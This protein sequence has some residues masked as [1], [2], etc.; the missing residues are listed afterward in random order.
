MIVR[1]RGTTAASPACLLGYTRAL[2]VLFDL[3]GTLT[4][5]EPGITRCL[6]HALASL[7]HPV[8]AVPD[9]RRFVGPPLGDT[10]ATLLG[11]SDEAQIR[12][13]VRCYRER[14]ET[15]GLYENA[16]YPDV[17]AGLERLRA[18][19]HRL[20]VVTSKPEV[21]AV[22]IVR[23]YRLEPSFEAVHGPELTPLHL[24]KAALVRQALEAARVPPRDAV[25]VGDRIHDV[26][27][28]RANGVAAV[29]VRW[30]YGT[31]EELTGA[32]PDALVSGM[33]GLC[34]WIESRA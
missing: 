5:P 25:M 33:D 10:F 32:G 24:E 16:V 21:Y 1:G 14:F 18:G 13:A 4:D 12:E 34:D 11:T 15:V 22:R 30:G 20:R 27:A 2:L 7:G 29:A 26:V 19:G 31:E 17:P 28:A 6:Q 23:H 8:P 9:L 3:D